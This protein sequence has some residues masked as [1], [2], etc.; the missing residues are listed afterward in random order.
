MQLTKIAVQKVDTIEGRAAL[1][2]ALN[3]TEQWV[4]KMLKAN[5]DNG[6][7]TSYV[8][9]EEISRVTGLAKKEI[10]K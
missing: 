9:V 6:P 4:N 10:L 8:A 1:M 2:V 5:K 7:L 3:C